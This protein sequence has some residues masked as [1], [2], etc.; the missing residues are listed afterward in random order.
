MKA[1]LELE[2]D[3]AVDS[4]DAVIVVY[5]TAAGVM[6]TVRIMERS[7]I[8][9]EVIAQWAKMAVDDFVPFRK[10]RGERMN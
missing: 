3:D 8:S 4:P 1:V 5:R 6:A 7:P 10:G 2:L 9:P